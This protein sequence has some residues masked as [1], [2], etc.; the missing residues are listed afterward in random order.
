M[1]AP[2]TIQSASLK[3]F[4]GKELHPSCVRG[5]LLQQGSTQCVSYVQTAAATSSFKEELHSAHRA[6]LCS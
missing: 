6:Y 3:K 4:P 1:P 2:D 5:S